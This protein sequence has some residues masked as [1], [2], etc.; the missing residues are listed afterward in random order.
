M[1]CVPPQIH[2]IHRRHPHVITRRHPVRLDSQNL[3][4]PGVACSR[5][6]VGVKLRLSNKPDDFILVI[7]EIGGDKATSRFVKP[8]R[9]EPDFGVTSVNHDLE[10]LLDRGEEPA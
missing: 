2:S 9:R 4:I 7:V 3:P 6:L 5:S 10:E 8:F 1:V